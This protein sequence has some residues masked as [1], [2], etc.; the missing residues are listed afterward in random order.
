M[1]TKI[2]TANQLLY[3]NKTMTPKMNETY[4]K[5]NLLFNFFLK[6]KSGEIIKHHE[7]KINSI[8]LIQKRKENH[9][10]ID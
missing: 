5:T 8:N 1:T 6:K 9:A 4:R 3:P 7:E 2:N 10:N